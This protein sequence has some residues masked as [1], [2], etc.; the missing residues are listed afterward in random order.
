MAGTISIVGV[1]MMT[2]VG[3]SAAMTAT[4]VQA[5]ISAYMSSSIYNKRF[6]P[7]TL[8]L[9]PEDALPPLHEELNKVAG[10]TSRQR[11]MLRLADK[12]LAEALSAAPGSITPPLLLAGPEETPGCPKPIDASFLKHLHVQG[13]G[14][15][16]LSRSKLF[17]QGRASGI[18]A[19]AQAWAM[20]SSETEPFVLV[21]GVDTY[22]DLYLLGTLDMHDRVLADGVMDGFAPGEGAA[23]LLLA[24]QQTVEKHALKRLAQVCQPALADEPGHRYSQAPY[25]GEGLAQAMTAALSALNGQKANTVFASMTGEN[26]HAKEWGVANIRN[27]SSLAEKLRFEHPAD[28]YGD[29]GAAAGPLMIG[30][31]A[32]GMNDGQIQGPCLVYC[33]SEHEKRGAMC[34]IKAK[35]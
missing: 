25:K 20:L 17:T 6:Q 19:M 24:S 15:F 33:S 21:G 29:P 13:K 27:Q 16:S 4:S 9:T 30:L 23:F 2:P 14:R 11:R 10:L 3:D 8:A 7:M 32:L 31:A 35:T 22:L 34:L 5:G 28:C 1:G 26:L 18:E 12:A